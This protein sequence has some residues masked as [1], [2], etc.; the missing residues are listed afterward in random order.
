MN[1]DFYSCL[2]GVSKDFSMYISRKYGRLFTKIV[3]FDVFSF[4][5]II[6]LDGILSFPWKDDQI[7]SSEAI[8]ATNS[9]LVLSSYEFLD[10]FGL[11]PLAVIF[12]FEAEQVRFL[13]KDY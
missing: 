3:L 4:L 7:S 6:N 11:F 8:Q 5:S 1:I 12:S 13:L 10:E 9:F 2:I